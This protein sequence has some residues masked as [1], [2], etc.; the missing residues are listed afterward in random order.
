MNSVDATFSIRQKATFF[1]S[2]TYTSPK[3]PHPRP[4]R[5]RSLAVTLGTAPRAA[6]PG[7]GA[8]RAGGSRSN[9]ATP[10][11]A[12]SAR[13]AASSATCRCAVSAT[14]PCTSSSESLLARELSARK[15]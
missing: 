4:R 3:E 10:A 9:G 13:T 8:G 14:R 2:S 15:A 7:S 1:S 5:T 12:W 11:R 6:L